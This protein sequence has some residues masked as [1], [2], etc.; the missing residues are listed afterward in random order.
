MNATLSLELFVDLV[1]VVVVVVVPN[2]LKSGT[3]HHTVGIVALAYS[4]K[5]DVDGAR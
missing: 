5:D 1:V 2:G 4:N 3:A